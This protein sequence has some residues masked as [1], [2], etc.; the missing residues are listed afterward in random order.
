[1]SSRRTVEVEQIG[2]VLSANNHTSPSRKATDSGD[3]DEFMVD[4]HFV[5]KFLH[6]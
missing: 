4:V 6:S 2:C 3:D 5:R 1:M